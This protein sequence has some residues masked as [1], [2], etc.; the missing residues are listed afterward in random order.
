MAVATAVTIA[1]LAVGA[2][3]ASQQQAAAKKQAK[4]QEHAALASATESYT[5]AALAKI[6]AERIEK[7]AGIEAD[8]IREAAIQMRSQ[9]EAVQG[10]SG[11]MV[12]TGSNLVMTED[13]T[14]RAEADAIATVIEGIYGTVN[15]ESTARYQQMA[16]QST[17]LSGGLAANAMLSAGR[18]GAV[19]TLANSAIGA[20][21]NYKQW[22]TKTPAATTTT[23]TVSTE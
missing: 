14:K 16:G 19:T 3:S 9:Q 22:N 23:T 12:G 20:Y 15:K 10:T 8:K 4:A 5:N 7:S 13:I 18:T 17:L 21:S 11:A 1:S 6:D 2:Y